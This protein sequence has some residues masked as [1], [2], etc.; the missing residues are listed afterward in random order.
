MSDLPKS[1]SISEEGPREG[2]QIEPG[3]IPTG[4]KIEL[5][6]A[7]SET[8]LKRIQVASFVSP[9]HVPGWADADD[10]V[11]GFRREPGVAYSVLWLNERGLD[12]ALGKEGIEMRGAI[13]T[14]ASETFMGKNTNRGYERNREVQKNQIDTYL[15]YGMPVR[16]ASVMAA[17]G[18]N[19]EGEVPVAKVLEAVRD[20]MEIAAEKG[21][22]IGTLS[23]ADTMGWAQPASIKAVVGAV[24][25][26]W[27][28]REIALHLHD[29]RGMGIAN[30]YAGLEMGV[31]KFD[32]SVAGLGG[33]PFA[34]HKGAAGN[35][36]TEDLVFL[37]EE[38]G[39][40]TGVDLDALIECARLAE[41]IVGHPLPGSVMHGGSL[42][43]FR[44]ARA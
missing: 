13:S 28:D 20:L 27:P 18:C 26:E 37:C 36:C 38:M 4:R 34:A 32:S 30:A 8:G 42:S 39:I 14:S 2:F 33:C 3:P 6:D 7:L 15:A 31:T 22:E 1:V 41:D 29:T 16:K 11:E 17:F 25:E 21:V 10:V 40:D 12:R 9:R 5:I 43:R 19:F 44:E 24:R 23:L 35:V